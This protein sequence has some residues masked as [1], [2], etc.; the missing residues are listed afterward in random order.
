MT[1]GF[2][3]T[4]FTGDSNSLA[5]VVLLMALPF[6]FLFVLS[7]SSIILLINSVRSKESKTA[8][9]KAKSQYSFG[10]LDALIPIGVLISFNYTI[11]FVIIM[12]GYVSIFSRLRGKK[13][14]KEI[15]YATF[16]LSAL[17]FFAVGGLFFVKLK[18]DRDKVRDLSNRAYISYSNY[19][20][21]YA[22][23]NGNDEDEWKSLHYGF[24]Y[25]VFGIIFGI[26]SYYKIRSIKLSNSR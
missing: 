23:S 24:S 1:T 25:T 11:G 2:S 4:D 18:S 7:I 8:L 20:A 17:L 10:L 21:Q 16:L 13:Y 15:F 9:N 3:L 14:S 26:T 5:L 19:Q 6:I 22:Y 12:L